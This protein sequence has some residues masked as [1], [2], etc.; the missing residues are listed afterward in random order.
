MSRHARFIIVAVVIAVAAGIAAGVGIEDGMGIAKGAIL[1]ARRLRVLA[2]PG[3]PDSGIAGRILMGPAC[4]EIRG[5]TCP[6]KPYVGAIAVMPLSRS[7]EVARVRAD[8]TG[9]FRV[10]LAPGIYYLILPDAG[11][12][13]RA[14]RHEVT[15]YPHRFTQVMIRVDTGIR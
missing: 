9:A 3:A 8:A 12:R 7:R 5:R 6:D 4:P 1:G 14:G 2:A 15:V 10:A 13:A 11:P